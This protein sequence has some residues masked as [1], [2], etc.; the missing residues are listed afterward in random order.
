MKCAICKN[1]TT[2][3][4][5]STIVLERN[6]MT[7]VFKRVPSQV[8]NNCGEEYISADINKELLKQGEHE[9]K[10]GVSVEMLNFAA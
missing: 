6:Q 8:C 10:R 3:E 4:G 2:K 5:F 7:L 1:G 9:Y